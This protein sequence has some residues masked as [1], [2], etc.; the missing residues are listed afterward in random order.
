M[1]YMRLYLSDLILTMQT[2]KQGFKIILFFHFENKFRLN[3]SAYT[4]S[5]LAFNL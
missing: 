4:S 3:F 1:L 2:K 5:N